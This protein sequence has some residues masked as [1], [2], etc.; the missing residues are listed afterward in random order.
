M[1]IG[2]VSIGSVPCGVTTLRVLVSVPRRGHPGDYNGSEEISP[3][4]FSL[5][6]TCIHE[7]LHE[8]DQRMQDFDRVWELVIEL[9]FSI[10]SA[11]AVSVQYLKWIYVVVQE[12][13]AATR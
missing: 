13:E 10:C 1:S 7:S 5:C 11:Q 8:R 3:V 4:S 6:S 9:Q 12:L 2:S